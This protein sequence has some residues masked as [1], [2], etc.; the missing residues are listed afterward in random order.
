MQLF[1]QG[2]MPFP[3]GGL[4]SFG[5]PFGGDT[6]SETLSDMGRSRKYRDTGMWELQGPM[7]PFPATI[8]RTPNPV[9]PLKF[10][11][12]PGKWQGEAE[13]G[14]FTAYVTACLSDHVLTFCVC[15][16]SERLDYTAAVRVAK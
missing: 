12:E 16:A 11:Q 3:M 1:Q 8:I 4:P 6:D 15:S 7:S 5:M 9:V 2:G 13:A 10:E 14:C